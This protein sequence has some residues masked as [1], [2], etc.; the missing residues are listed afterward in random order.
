MPQDTPTTP[1][2]ASVDVLPGYFPTEL[3]AGLDAAL[4]SAT[5][6]ELR[7][8]RPGKGKL[9]LRSRLTIDGRDVIHGS[10]TDRSCE[11]IAAECYAHAEGDADSECSGNAVYK[12]TLL[13]AKPPRGITRGPEHL[14]LRIGHILDAPEQA[15]RFDFCNMLLS[16]RKE[17]FAQHLAL[18]RTTTTL[19]ASVAIAVEKLAGAFTELHAKQSEVASATEVTAYAKIQA[20]KDA[21]R[22][23]AMKSLVSEFAPMIRQQLGLPEAEPVP[24]IVALARKLA[25]SMRPDQIAIAKRDIP[26]LLDATSV[27]TEED[28]MLFVAQVLQQGADGKIEPMLRTL[29]AAQQELFEKIVTWSNARAAAKEQERVASES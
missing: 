27:K 9:V 22:F 10:R 16:D 15:Q 14:E 12:I 24:E 17:L 13:Y 18:M 7:R 1:I 2:P 28:L 11:D 25:L 19:A 8:V 5:T 29:D 4:D 3:A 21:T 20:E 26:R 23:E 6:V